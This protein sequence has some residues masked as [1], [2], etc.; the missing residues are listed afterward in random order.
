MDLVKQYKT[1]SYI[2][3]LLEYNYFPI[4][5]FMLL[6]FIAKSY[7]FIL[8]NFLIPFLSVKM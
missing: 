1:Y 3:K 7:A 5:N 4:F 8:H 6:F 2:S